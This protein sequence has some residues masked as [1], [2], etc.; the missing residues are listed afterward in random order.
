MGI[1]EKYCI[2]IFFLKKGKKEL[3][4]YPMT[5]MWLGSKLVIKIL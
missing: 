3:N 2:E 5:K 1:K 4:R